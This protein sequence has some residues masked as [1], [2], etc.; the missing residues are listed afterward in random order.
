MLSSSPQSTAISTPTPTANTYLEFSFL[1]NASLDIF[2]ERARDRNR[3]D[4]DLGLLQRIDERLAIWGWE[5]GTGTRFAI[6]VDYGV[7]PG[8]IGV[9]AG[10]GEGGGG[11]KGVSLFSY[12]YFCESNVWRE[13]FA[14]HQWKD[15]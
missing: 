11:V 2:E 13:H 5:T 3:I 8:V 7:G 6:V 14:F 1:L 9:G 4:Q 12:F 10:A 15:Y